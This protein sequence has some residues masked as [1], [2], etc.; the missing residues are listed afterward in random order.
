MYNIS[1]SLS[2][3]IYIYMYVYTHIYIY[4]PSGRLGAG[5]LLAALLVRAYVLLQEG[6]ELG[7][8]T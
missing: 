5:Q 3:Y 1:L 7:L 4:R 6:D 2:I 8:A